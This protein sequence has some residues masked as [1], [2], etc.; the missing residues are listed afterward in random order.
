MRTDSWPPSRGTPVRHPWN[1]HA[2]EVVPVAGRLAVTPNPVRSVGEF[3]LP[4]AGPRV[5]A[6]F[7]SQG[8]LVDRLSG[9]DGHWVWTPG[10]TAPAGVYFARLDGGG[11]IGEPVKFLYLR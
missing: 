6:I 9:S 11:A 8:R 2:D 1:T 10:A 7:D 4:S 5:L 3:A